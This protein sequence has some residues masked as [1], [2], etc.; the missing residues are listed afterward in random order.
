MWTEFI[1][2][3]TEACDVCGK[4]PSGSVKDIEYLGSMSHH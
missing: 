2:L 1:W 4:G 3:K